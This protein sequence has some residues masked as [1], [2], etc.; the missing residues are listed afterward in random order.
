MRTGSLFSGYAGLDGAVNEV[1]G[2][3]TVWHSEID[4]GALKILRHRFPDVPNIGN[5]TT[6]DWSQVEPVD[7]LTGGSPCQDLS[8]A[9]KRPA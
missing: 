3:E 6:A 7:I 5:V 8:H 1:F 2:S 9:G 4:K